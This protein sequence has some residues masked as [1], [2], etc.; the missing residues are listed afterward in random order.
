MDLCGVISRPRPLFR[1]L[2]LCVA[3][4]FF[5][6]HTRR[7][8]CEQTLCSSAYRHE[9]LEARNAV[10]SCEMDLTSISL[11]QYLLNTVYTTVNFDSNSIY[12]LY[13]LSGSSFRVG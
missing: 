10:R 12:R 6:R 8:R 9:I 7:G 11:A 1:R 4:R 3:Q 2:D 13:D 5:R